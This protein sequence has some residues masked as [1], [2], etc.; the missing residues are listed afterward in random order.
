MRL[1]SKITVA[2]SLAS[3]PLAWASESTALDDLIAAA[4]QEPAITVY[5]STGKIVE[6][7]ANFSA[8]YGV[9]AEGVKSKA[10]HTLERIIREAQANN[11]Q[12]DVAILADA[13]A[14]VAQLLDTGFAVNWFPADLAAMVDERYRDPLAIV[15]APNVWTYNTALHNHCPIDNIWELTEPEWERRVALQDPLG[16]PSYVDWFNQMAQHG[17]E[18][19]AAAF[20]ARYGHPLP[21]TEESATAAWVKAL[22]ANAPLLTDSDSNAAEAVASPDQ[23]D[24]FL[25]LTSTAK[26]RDN[27]DGMKLGICEDLDPWLGWTYPSIGLIASGTQSPNAAKLFLYYLLTEEG[28]APQAQDGKISTRSDISLPET[29]PSGIGALK[30]QLFDYSP[31]TAID[32]WENRQDWQ[33]LWMLNYRR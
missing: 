29:E 14:A 23:Q 4:R 8:R 2:I 7:A 32:D 25:G 21:D 9:Q 17:D 22:A 10:P 5:D 11:I 24:S 6:Q 12:T 30:A 3:T 26:F 19:M 31:S 18:A 16:K 20:E 15:M 28:I 33:D 1:L 27:A 13:P